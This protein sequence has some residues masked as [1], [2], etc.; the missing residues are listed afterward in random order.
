MKRLGLL[1]LS[2]SAWA[3]DAD[4]Y[5]AIRNNDLA[6]VKTVDVQITDRRGNTPLQYAAAFGSVEAMRILLDRGADVNAR[7][8]FDATP[9]I[10]AASYP[11]KARLLIERGADVNAKSR[12]LRTP[13][14]VAAACDGCSDIVKLLLAKGADPNA[15]AANGATALGLAAQKGEPES[16][17]LLLAAGA[18]P[19]AATQ[20]GI[21]PLHGSA[22]NCDTESARLLLAKGAKVDVANT[23]SGKVKFGDIQ[24][25]HLTPLAISGGYCHENF[26]ETLLSAGASPKTHDIRGM[27]PL[28]LAVASETQDP[29]VVRRLIATGAEIDPAAVEWARK[30][31][32]PEILALLHA[33]SAP[34]AV[35][36]PD[37]KPRAAREAIDVAVPLLQKTAVEFHRQSGCVGCHHQPVAVLASAIA[38]K[39]GSEEL[40]RMMV[41]ELSGR[42]DQWMQ[43]VDGGGGA[44]SDGY[45]ILALNAARYPADAITDAI[46]VHTAVQQRRAGNW[47]VGDS[48]RP[49]IQDSD[50]ARTARAMRTLQLYAPP[51]LKPEF[52][53][54]V[55]RARDYILAARPKTN[56]DFAMQ[57]MG[58]HWAGVPRSKIQQLGRT[59]VAAQRSD[60][61]WSSNANLASDV[62][63][64]GETLWV[65]HES[66]VLKPTD[67]AYRRGVK[68]LLSTQ[69]PDGSWHVL[70]RAPK[71][72]PYFESGF[73]FGHDQWISSAATAY[74]VMAVAPAIEKDTKQ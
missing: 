53:A 37:G 58:A 13:L 43:R 26:I 22:E 8:G 65:L 4:I 2:W 74:A 48:A 25:I 66:G 32:T 70:S 54:R 47:H 50:I 36:R 73:P 55:A 31:N 5:T 29:A 45:V 27:S 35:S 38:G 56:D 11:A 15:A 24:L 9:L 46:A 14:M 42:Q 19:N 69:F 12:Q 49:P 41:A 3:G 51:A 71:F 44:D 20:G 62:Y 28:T 18:D 23:S 10:W 40:V 1:L 7:N 59:L 61:G 39:G 33:K 72:Q 67:T 57:L 17:R 68:F 64:T 21:T 30:Y 52:D 63:A 34:P 6:A 16:V 60:G